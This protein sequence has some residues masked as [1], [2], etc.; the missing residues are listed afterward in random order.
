MKSNKQI[1]AQSQF[2]STQKTR[3]SFNRKEMTLQQGIE[4]LATPK[5]VAMQKYDISPS[6][7]NRINNSVMEYLDIQRSNLGTVIGF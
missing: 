5:E 6:T 4:F 2:S 1:P 3:T 7:W